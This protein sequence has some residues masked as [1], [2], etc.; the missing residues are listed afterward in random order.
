MKASMFLVQ[1]ASIL[2]DWYRNKQLCKWQTCI[3]VLYHTMEC[4][5]QKC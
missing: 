1:T 4:S 2:C 3:Y 5:S